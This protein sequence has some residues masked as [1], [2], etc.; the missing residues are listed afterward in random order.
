MSRLKYQTK[1]L[2]RELNQFNRA[3]FSFIKKILHIQVLK[4]E[5]GKTVFATALYRKRG[6]LAKRFI[7]SGMAGITAL[8]IIIA[9]VVADELGS[10]RLNPW[11]A[12]SPSQVLSASAQDSELGTDFSDKGYRDQ[13]IEYTVGE[14][15][16]VSSIAKKFDI[17]EDTIRW[18]NDLE[19]KHAIKVGQKLQI[20]PIT[21]IS[22]KVVKGDTIYSISKK[23][24]ADPQSIV[25]FPFNTFVNDETFELAIGQVVIVPEGVKKDDLNP[26]STPRT[27]QITPNA[28]TVVASGNFVWPTQGTITQKYSWYHPGMDIAN[29]ASPTVVAAD[30]GKV[31]AAGWDKTGYGNMVMIDHG[32]GYKTRYGHLQKIYV[33]AG[34]TVS[35]GSAIGQMGTTGHSTGT[36]L[37]FEIYK[38]ATRIN[39]LGVLK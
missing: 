17:S 28:G 4:F 19:S 33:V 8:G 23:Y 18:Q 30:S 2:L 21:G 6:R 37:H 3:F 10:H 13:T 31:I 14:G 39:P 11:D 1:L 16:T 35:R 25:D 12:A 26:S 24:D 20:L 22:H 15:D 7:H 36:H 34:Q 27:K 9:P 38:G 32:N 29:R 5:A